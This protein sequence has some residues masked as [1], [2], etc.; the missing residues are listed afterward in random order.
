MMYSMPDGG[1]VHSYTYD[2]ENP[3]SL[4]DQSNTMAG[5]QVLYTMAAVLRQMKGMNTL[6]DFRTEIG[7]NVGNGITVFSDDDKQAADSLPSPLTTEQYVTVVKLLEKLELSSGFNDKEAYRTKLESAKAEIAGIQK[8]VDDLNADIHQQLYPLESLTLS[9]REKVIAIIGRY[10][11]LSPYDREKIERWEDV[12]K[13]ETKLNNQLR[14][15]IIGII[16]SAVAAG[17]TVTVVLRARKRRRA[18]QSA[19]DALAAEYADGDDE[20]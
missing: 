9:D 11:A 2:D 14:G 3:T 5:E 6:Y 17:A 13:T 1:F 8:E 20:T 16:I 7:D 18:K 19:M 10:N 12:I 4:P 15:I